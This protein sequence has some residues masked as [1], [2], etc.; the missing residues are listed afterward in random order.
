[1]KAIKYMATVISIAMVT[2]NAWGTSNLNLSKSNVNREFPNASIATASVNLTGPGDTQVIYTTPAKGDFML[3]Q[4]CASPDAPGG[5][6]LDAAGF[7]GIAQ[8]G[9][10]SCLTFSP[11]VS[12][13]K[14]AALS[15]SI[16][17]TVTASASTSS[18][19]IVA[20]FFCTISGMQTIK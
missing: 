7:G 3:T 15:C 9:T 17:G 18:A 20:S 12:I 2:T 11:G 4:F 16:G 6:R 5:V 14:G 1:L 19:A 10:T 13:P 8:T